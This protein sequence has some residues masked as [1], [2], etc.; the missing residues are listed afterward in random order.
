MTL[1][2]MLERFNENVRQRIQEDPEYR[3]HILDELSRAIEREDFEAARY[4]IELIQGT[5]SSSSASFP[6]T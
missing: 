4:L 6:K 1:T 5:N 2:P 3:Q